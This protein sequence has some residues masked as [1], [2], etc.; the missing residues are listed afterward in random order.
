MRPD[1]ELFRVHLAMRMT[2]CAFMILLNLFLSAPAIKKKEVIAYG[3]EVK[4]CE[5]DAQKV[6]TPCIT[7]TKK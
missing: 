2:G 7:D 6:V 1:F 4:I 3:L 5:C